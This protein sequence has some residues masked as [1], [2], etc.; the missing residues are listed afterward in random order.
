MQKDG[1]SCRFI[2]S[3]WI[4]VLLHVDSCFAEGWILVLLHVDSCFATRGFLFCYTWILVLLK[5]GF[6]FCWRMHSCFA[7]GRIIVFCHVVSMLVEAIK[8]PASHL[9][10]ECRTCCCRV[11]YC[12]CGV[13][14]KEKDLQ[15]SKHAKNGA[16]TALDA[17]LESHSFIH[18][19]SKEKFAPC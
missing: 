11:C 19:C 14:S 1:F 17:H 10:F 7:A 15:Q 8:T 2:C 5:D 4:L 12:W 16:A 6:L 13:C 18:S 3:R 9:G